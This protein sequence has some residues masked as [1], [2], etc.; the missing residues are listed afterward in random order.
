MLQKTPEFS[1]KILF[2]KLPSEVKAMH[3][4]EKKFKNTLKYFFVKN[5]FY[6][7]QEYIE[8]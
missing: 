8:R 2:N 4:L 3:G 6:S 5:A 7:I 1:G